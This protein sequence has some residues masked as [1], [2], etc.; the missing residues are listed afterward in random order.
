MILVKNWQFFHL[1]NTGIPLFFLDNIGEENVF[2]NILERKKPFS[3][4]KTRF[5]KR[6]KM[7]I[8]PKGLTH[9]F[10]PKTFGLFSIFSFLAI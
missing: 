4:I 1:F 7:K 9:G 6:R 8:F 10:G 3:A 2:Y 5:S